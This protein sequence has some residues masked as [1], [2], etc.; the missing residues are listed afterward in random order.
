MRKKGLMK[1]ETQIS[2]FTVILFCL[3]LMP[4]RTKLVK[5]ENLLKSPV[6][7]SDGTVTFNYQGDGSEDHVNFRGEFTGWENK[8]ATVNDKNLWSI[9]LV[10][11]SKI[12][13]QEYGFEAFL[14]E[15][16]ST[17]VWK[18][19]ILNAIKATN[20]NPMLVT[21]GYYKLDSL[22]SDLEIGKTLQ[23]KGY[24]L[25][26]D[27]KL[28]EAQNIKWSVN[29]SDIAQISED[30]VLKSKI[31]S[32]PVGVNSLPVIVSGEKDGNILTKTINIVSEILKA[33][34]LIA[35]AGGKN[36]WYVAGSFQGWKNTNPDTQLKHLDRKSVV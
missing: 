33:D 17:G 4:I 16:V 2:I 19:D 25:K 13:M 24:I 5:A 30:G 8:A 18:G 11:P 26:A 35:Q 31:T 1:Y 21:P 6:I 36:K 27:G 29:N 23:I 20:G 28:E 10:Q 32:L 7:N 15:D 22:S 14:K 12:G 3:T 34:E 9:T